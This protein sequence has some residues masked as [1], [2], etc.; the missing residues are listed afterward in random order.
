MVLDWREKLRYDDKSVR[1]GGL[2][3]EI[4]FIVGRDSSIIWWEKGIGLWIF[5]G[6]ILF[7]F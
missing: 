4:S 1:G 7:L 3:R 2:Y 6:Y 5:K